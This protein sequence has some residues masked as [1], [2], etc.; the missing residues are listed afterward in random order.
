MV[1]VIVI[2]AATCALMIAGVLFFPE[3]R[4]GKLKFGSYW[5]ITLLGAAALLASCQTDAA[6]I[7]KALIADTAVNPLK[8]L[9]LF[10]SMTI[11]SV[12]LDEL[13][14]FGFL[15]A[16]VLKRA[17]SGQKRLFFTLYITVSLLTVVTSN[18]IIVLSFTPFICY[19]AKNAKID[20]V[21]YLAAEFVAANTWSMLLII[22][23]PT[24]IYLATAYGIDF[25]TYLKYSIFPTLFAG[26]TALAALYLMF[27]KK[28]SAPITGEAEEQKIGD[29]FLLAV[30]LAH[31]GVCTVLLAVGSYIG[32]E[33]WIIALSSAG[34]LALFTL[35]TSAVRRQKPKALAGCL[36]RA[37]WQL[38]PFVL[39]MFVLIE[40]LEQKG[41]TAA[42]GNFFG[43]DY[44]ALKYG[45]SSFFAA[46]LINN[47]P[48]S[49]LFS[50]IISA[51][52]GAATEAVFGAVIGS[53]LGAFFTP[54]GAL[55][56]I[57]WTEILTTHGLKFGYA[58][59]LK[60]GVAVALPALFAAIGG[61][62]LSLLVFA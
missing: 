44:A 29:K 56:G 2:A 61:L 39:S 8:I 25:I 24:N 20:P 14:F 53:N 35:I 42:I 43:S 51:A 54:I 1:A 46:N 55:A 58:D 36:K 17:R 22:G 49:V 10:I 5:V 40:G 31:L 50:S 32:L 6:Q 9:V 59:F 12:F 52:G 37:P 4:I 18:D 57:M 33:M 16:A 19:F 3:I 11:L 13:G 60:I 23:N 26:A 34:S 38:I 7:G 45:V 28:L 47:I 30:G 48:M 15:A 41:V 21:P 27:K 62:Y